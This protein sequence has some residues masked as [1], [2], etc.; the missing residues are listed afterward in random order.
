[1]SDTAGAGADSEPLAAAG[2]LTVAANSLVVRAAAI[3]PEEEAD[4]SVAASLAAWPRQPR[5][6][7]AA[8]TSPA[9]PEPKDTKRAGKRAGADS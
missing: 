4:H 7:P 9:I 1:M 6:K 3:S 5:P 8:L 2:K